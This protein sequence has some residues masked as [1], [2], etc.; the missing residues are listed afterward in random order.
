MAA[1]APN[2]DMPALTRNTMITD[3]PKHSTLPRPSAP[4]Q[5]KDTVTRDKAVPASRRRAAQTTMTDQSSYEAAISE[6]WPVFA[7][8]AT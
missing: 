2:Q 3:L 6:G 4:A 5:A 8:S 7:T 1:R